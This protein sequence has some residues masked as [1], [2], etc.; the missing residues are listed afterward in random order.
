MTAGLLG[1]VSLAGRMG[2]PLSSTAL[3]RLALASGVAGIGLVAYVALLLFQDLYWGAPPSITV[4][5]LTA[6]CDAPS[7]GPP[8]R[9]TVARMNAGRF[10][11]VA[12]RPGASVAVAVADR[13]AALRTRVLLVRATT[14]GRMRVSDGTDAPPLAT[15]DVGTAD[16]RTVVQLPDTSRGWSTVSFTPVSPD[17]DVA[18]DEIG[19]F[20]DARGLLR[21]AGQPF[22]RISMYSFFLRLAPIAAFGVC[23]WLAAMMWLLPETIASTAGP[24]MGGALCLA[25]GVLESAITFSPHWFVDTRMYYA[26]LWVPDGPPGANLLGGLQEG[27]RFVQGLGLT[28]MDGFVQWHRMP[29]YGLFC[30]LAAAV[31]RTTNLI[32]M[33]SMVI[34]LQCVFYAV[35]LVVFVAAAQRLFAPRVAFLVGVLIVLMPQ[36]LAY[37]QVDSI[38]ASLQLLVLATLMRYLA[39][40]RDGGAPLARFVEVNLAFALWFAMR[41][42]VTP[43]WFVIAGVLAYRRWGRLVLPAALLLAIAVPW[44]VYKRQ[45]QHEFSLMP[46]NMGEVL[47]LGLCEVPGAFP[48]ECVDD[49]YFAWAR[50]HGFED[51]TTSSA[52]SHASRE[53]VRHWA[54]YPVHFVFMV[55]TKAQAALTTE[56]FPGFSTA[57]NVMY[58][59]IDESKSRD[60]HVFYALLLVLAASLAVWYEG[61]RTLLVG[62]A[63]F[64]NMPIF[65]V[66]FASNGRFYT[67]P[68]ISLVA[69]TVP[70]LVDRGFYRA[71]AARPLRATVAAGCVLLFAAGAGP[72][73]RFVMAH[74]AIHYWSPLL[75]PAKS[76]LR[77]PGR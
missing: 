3:R 16:V 8:C 32:E 38:V 25:V 72:A 77:F 14:P 69:A 71:I 42:D 5:A 65:F 52:S 49:G 73:E 20:A 23:L 12:S 22:Q 59:V 19:F 45:Y 6:S 47:L 55:M 62:W 33:A 4:P 46:T 60:T 40:E 58:T 61:R 68:A 50:S 70:L 27:S 76:S 34:V 13:G 2:V 28:L 30:A 44:G 7:S 66:M 15:V 11:V 31:A 18:L 64:L 26:K 67:A 21:P 51:P 1:R 56:S 36:Q 39:A 74:D 10:R 35:S 75:D 37:T 53:A 57:L 43:G 54:T 63:L 41:S 29:G 9:A 48:Y 24:W 17:R